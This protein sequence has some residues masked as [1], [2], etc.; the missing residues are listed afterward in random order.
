MSYAQAYADWSYLW[1]TYGPAS[2]MTGAYVDQ[3]DLAALLKSPTK[4]TAEKCLKRQ[5]DYWFDVGPDDGSTA[6]DPS[7]ERLIEI[8]E[9]YGKEIP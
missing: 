6:P 7:D 8:A 9:R 5:I 3:D 4:N 1:E 2:D